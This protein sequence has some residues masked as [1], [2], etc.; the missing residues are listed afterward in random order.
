[1][2]NRIAKETD[3]MHEPRDLWNNTDGNNKADSLFWNETN[4]P[5]RPSHMYDTTA[6]TTHA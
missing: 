4:Y 3:A 1:M 5:D 2:L 6:R